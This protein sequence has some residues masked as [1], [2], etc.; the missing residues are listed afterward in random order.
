MRR[1]SNRNFGDRRR[2]Y[3]ENKIY[4]LALA[5]ETRILEACIYK[6]INLAGT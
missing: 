1:E 5:V 3:L 6:Y 2:E 4:E